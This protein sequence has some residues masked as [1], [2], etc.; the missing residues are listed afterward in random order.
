MLRITGYSD[1]Y[2]IRPGDGITFYVN[3]ENGEDYEAKLVRLI[4]GDTN[5]D[6]PGYKEEEIDAPFDGTCTGATRRSTAAPT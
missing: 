2:S 6:G 1:C 4:H 5:P 3:S